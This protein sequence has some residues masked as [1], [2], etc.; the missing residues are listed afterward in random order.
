MGAGF[1]EGGGGEVGL[2][3][4]E[5]VVAGGVEGVVVGGRVAEGG[6]EEGA[7][8]HGGRRGRGRGGWLLGGFGHFSG[9]GFEFYLA[10]SK[11]DRRVRGWVLRARRSNG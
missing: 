4:L 10:R 8:S 11:R 2:E 9:D 5:E 7:G 1:G 3:G 6:D